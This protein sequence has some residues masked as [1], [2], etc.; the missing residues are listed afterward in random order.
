M[1][2]RGG[3]DPRGQNNSFD[4]GTVGLKMCDPFRVGLCFLIPDPVALPTT[5]E[6]HAFGVTPEIQKPVEAGALQ[7]AA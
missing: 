7:T 5:I 6:F 4:P 2:H 1:E 3:A